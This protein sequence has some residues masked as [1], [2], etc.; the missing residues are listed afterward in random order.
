[1]EHISSVFR[2]FFVH[3]LDQ[4]LKTVH[5]NFFSLHVLNNLKKFS[6]LILIKSCLILIKSCL[7]LIKSCLILI[8]SC[9]MLIKSCLILIK[10]CL[11]LIKS[12]LILIK[13]CLILIKS[14][15]T[16]IGRNLNYFTARFIFNHKPFV[17]KTI[18]FVW[19][20][21]F[22]FN[23]DFVKTF[24]SFFLASIGTW[25]QICLTRNCDCKTSSWLSKF[26]GNLFFKISK[27]S[28][29]LIC[30]ESLCEPNN[31]KILN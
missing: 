19:L 20:L 11:I 31:L 2:R 13:S 5:S 28:R 26:E 3:L 10:S 1:M 18:I 6:C 24:F 4:N 29:L 8:K 27:I 30:E 16:L 9:L 15:K 22:H 12:C 25:K 14:M 21:S 7:I 23:F 17:L